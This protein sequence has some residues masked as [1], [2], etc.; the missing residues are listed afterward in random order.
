[1]MTVAFTQGHE[2]MT[3]RDEAVLERMK[4]VSNPLTIIVLFAALAEVAG[5]AAPA[6]EP[7]RNVMAA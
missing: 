6:A 3:V 7:G 5:T 1:M 4:S 2:S